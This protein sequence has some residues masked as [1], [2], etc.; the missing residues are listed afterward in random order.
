M[1]AT[2]AALLSIGTG[3]PLDGHVQANNTLTNAEK[4]AGWKLLFDGRTTQGWHNFKA[5]GVS[6]G[7]QVENGALVIKDSSK[8]GDIITDEQFDWFEL[9]LDFNM[10]KGENSGIMYRVTEEGKATWHSGPEIQLYDSTDGGVQKTGWLYQLYES[11]VDSTKPAGEWNT[12]RILVSPTKSQTD[13]NGVK[14]YEYSFGSADFWARVAKSKFNEFPMFAKA[15]KGSIAIQGDHGKVA[16]RNIK[17]RP[18]K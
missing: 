12:M 8:A 16:F 2:L 18:I 7:W 11:K 17:I 5:K 3:L 9:T 1:I 13:V 4:K 14:Y 6:E 15:A 10:G